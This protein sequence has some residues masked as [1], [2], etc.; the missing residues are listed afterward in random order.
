MAEAY[1]QAAWHIPSLAEWSILFGTLD[2]GVAGGQIK[3]M[4]TAHWK[5]PNKGA[6]NSSGFTG[7][8]RRNR[9]FSNGLSDKITEVG[10]WWSSTGETGTLAIYTSASYISEGVLIGGYLDKRHG[11]SIRCLKN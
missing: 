10:Y 7:Q 5:T 6:T 3:E 1:V 4:G 2:G 9:L 8:P 11:M